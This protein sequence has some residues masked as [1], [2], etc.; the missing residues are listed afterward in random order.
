MLR[1]KLTLSFVVFSLVA[2]QACRQ[3]SMD[4]PAG[5]KSHPRFKPGFNL[6][7]PQQDV[8]MGQQSAAQVMRETPM[9]DDAQIGG[10][11]TQLGLKLASKAA[12]GRFP[13]Q[14]CVGGTKEIKALVLPCGFLF[15]HARALI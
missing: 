10:Y 11:I 5:S 6:F 12:G 9:L 14:F 8:Q 1:R 7:S 3:G 4:A 15:V 2:G 13:Y